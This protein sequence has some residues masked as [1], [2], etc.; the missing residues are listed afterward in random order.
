MER[1]RG[2]VEL[3]WPGVSDTGLARSHKSPQCSRLLGLHSAQDTVA[4]NQ[5]EN[6]AL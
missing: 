1:E 6:F 2:G 5:L 4:D 3:S